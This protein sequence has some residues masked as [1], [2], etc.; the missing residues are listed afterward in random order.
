MSPEQLSW[1]LKRL[2]QQAG[3]S[4]QALAHRAGVSRNFVA[5]IERGESLPTVGVLRRLAAALGTTAAQLLGEEGEGSKNSDLVLVP[6]VADR[7]AAGPPAYVNDQIES[8]EPLPSSLLQ[9][10]GVDPQQAILIRLGKDQDSMAET[11]PPGATV[12]IDRTPVKHVIPRHIYALREE[13]GD[14]Y[15]CTIKRLVL[16]PTSRVLILLSDNPAHLP[17]AIRLR[18]GQALSEIVIGRVLWWVPAS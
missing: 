3:L 10:L 14:S 7:I 12:L 4:Q 5:Q 9:S 16:D 18:P 13:A 8:Y 6:L 2:R 11:I 17:R 15:G 1:R